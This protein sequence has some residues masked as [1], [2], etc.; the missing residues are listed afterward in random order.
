MPPLAYALVTVAEAKAFIAPDG[1]AGTYDQLLEVVIN[2]ATDMIE[3]EYCN[4]P[5]KARTYTNLRLRGQERCELFLRA[6]P[7]DPAQ[8]ITVTVNGVA[9][10]VWRTEADGDP[11]SKDVIL[12]RSC[13]DLIF[14][15]D[16]LYRRVGWGGYSGNPYNVLLGYTGGFATVPNDLAEATLEIVKKLFNEMKAGTQDLA[17]VTLPSGSFTVFDATL[18]RRAREL[19]ERYVRTAAIA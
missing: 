7:I 2:R 10:T 15:P 9:Q 3:Q 8:P 4:R 1:M 14:T 11:A 6:T 18:P 13:D 19:L 5:L 12:G 16:H 17:A